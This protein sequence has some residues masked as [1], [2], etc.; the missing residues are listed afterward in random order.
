MLHKTKPAGAAT[1]PASYSSCTARIVA[2]QSISARFDRLSDEASRLCREAAE[3]AQER[4]E[5][6]RR[7][8]RLAQ[9]I[10]ERD[11]GF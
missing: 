3:L 7:I 4:A 8:D 6:R 1:P 10:E 2:L 9:S 11:H 5:L